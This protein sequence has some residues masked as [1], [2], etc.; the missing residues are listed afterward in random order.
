MYS[1]TDRLKLIFF[2]CG[3][4]CSVLNKQRSGGDPQQEAIVQQSIQ[5]AP[6][7]QQQPGG[8]AGFQQ[9]PRPPMQQG[10]PPPV[11]FC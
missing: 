2:F 6:W 9:T 7:Q 3:T 4:L 1:I 8:F 11:N 10:M 5:N